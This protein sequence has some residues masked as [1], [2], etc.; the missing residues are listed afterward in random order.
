MEQLKLQI[1]FFVLFCFVAFNLKTERNAHFDQFVDNF[2]PKNQI[3]NVW[4]VPGT[5]KF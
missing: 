4:E 1:V 3:I 2:V 5:R